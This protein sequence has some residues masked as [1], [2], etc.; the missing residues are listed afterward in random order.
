MEESIA[1]NEYKKKL[2]NT[3][4]SLRYWIKQAQEVSIDININK[5]NNNHLD[6]SAQP[7]PQTPNPNPYHLQFV[8]TKLPAM[9]TINNV[10]NE[11]ANML[12]NIRRHIDKAHQL[13][14]D[15]AGLEASAPSKTKT[16]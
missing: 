8:D 16:R 12:K 11:T 3:Q 15:A 7:Q 6:P 5:L 10:N 4:Q 14:I 13:G 9:N 1:E 2:N